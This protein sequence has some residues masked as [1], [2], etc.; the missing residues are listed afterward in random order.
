MGQLIKGNWKAV[1]EAL[2]EFR[3]TRY[4]FCLFVCLFGILNSGYFCLYVYCKIG[5]SQC[6]LVETNL[7]SIYEDA[8]LIPG[9]DQWVKDLALP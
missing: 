5:S 7:T 6:G 3:D 9:L 4:I 1:L 8:G 2:V